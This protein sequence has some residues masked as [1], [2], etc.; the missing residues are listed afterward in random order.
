MHLIIQRVC[1]ENICARVQDSR[2]QHAFGPP[3]G[4][5]LLTLFS[6]TA[7]Y[8]PLLARSLHNLHISINPT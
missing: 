3:S 5:E 1:A 8:P 4:I 2:E 7:P 6:S